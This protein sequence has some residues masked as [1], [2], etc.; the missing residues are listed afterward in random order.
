MSA[1]E[2]GSG[3][4]RFPQV[5]DRRVCVARLDLPGGHA[6][7]DHRARQTGLLLLQPLDLGKGGARLV[8]SAGLAES[9]SKV[10]VGL[11]QPRIEP[12]A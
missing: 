2:V 12:L 3:R 4:D 6:D 5:D 9:L 1:G 7:Q 10:H 11:G 8:L